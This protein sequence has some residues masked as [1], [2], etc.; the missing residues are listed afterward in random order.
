MNP[1]GSSVLRSPDGIE[2]GPG[3]LMKDCYGND[4]ES[5]GPFWF[6]EGTRN[7]LHFIE[8]LKFGSCFSS[9]LVTLFNACVMRK[10]FWRVPLLLQIVF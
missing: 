7:A 6:V 9:K 4:A 3:L 8:L 1:S 5:R 10:I 2:H